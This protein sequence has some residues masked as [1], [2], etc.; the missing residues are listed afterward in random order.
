MK[1]TVLKFGFISGAAMA[2]FM[3]ATFPFLH[4]LGFDAGLVVGYT[5]IVLAF[6]LVF[7]GIRSYRDSVKGGS[8]GYWR[9]VVVGTFIAV[10][11]SLCYTATWE[12]LSYKFAPNFG[13]E[14]ADAAVK[15]ARAGGKSDAEVAKVRVDMQRFVENYK[16][17]F[18]SSAM[19]FIEPFPVGLVIALVSA[20]I[21]RRKEDA[22]GALLAT[23]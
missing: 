6:L 10:I 13:Q 2:V 15:N 18:Y 22:D 16:N 7:F 17:P 3:G 14:Y 11:S 9:G 4:D 21:L 8:I 5:G 20:G 1:K 19:T 12:V 23:A